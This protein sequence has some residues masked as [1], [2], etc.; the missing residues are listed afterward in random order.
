MATTEAFSASANSETV[1]AEQLDYHQ[2]K[3]A[4]PT[5]KYNAQFSNT[6]GQAIN[7]GVSNTPVTI[8]I[9]PEV[10]NMSQAYIT[11]SV[12]LPGVTGI[13]LM[14]IPIIK[15]LQVLQVQQ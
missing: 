6:F 14:I 13:L 4:H 9:P 5:Y 2:K 12:T 3:F 11:Y 8:N 15:Q 10:M 1:I 7:L